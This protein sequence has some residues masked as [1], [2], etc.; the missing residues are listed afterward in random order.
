[1]YLTNVNLRTS[2]AKYT[3]AMNLSDLNFRSPLAEDGMAVNE[4]IGR[5]PPLDTNSSYCNLLQCSDFSDT[6]I[7]A[8]TPDNEVVGFI[9][10]YLPPQRPETLFV[11]QVALDEKWRGKGLAR[12]ML[13]DLFE[14]QTNVSHLETT[15]S[16]GNTASEHL[17]KR[18]FASQNMMVEKTVRFSQKTHFANKHPDEV[19]YRGGPD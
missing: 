4:L 14:R 9:S 17:F 7:V 13:S 16:P 10:G 6:S 5:C 1:M 12:Q 3:M 19:L 8:V 15:I 11:W 18:F 2:S